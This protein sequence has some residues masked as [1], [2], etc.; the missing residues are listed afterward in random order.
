VVP[1]RLFF[2][3]W[4]QLPALDAG[5]RLAGAEAVRLG[6]LLVE[7]DRKDRSRVLGEVRRLV[8]MAVPLQYPRLPDDL[9]PE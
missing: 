4:Q 5:E 1:V 2:L 6:K 3:L 9:T 8:R 7:A